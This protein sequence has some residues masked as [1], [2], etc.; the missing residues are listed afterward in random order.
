MEAVPIPDGVRG[1][2]HRGGALH[3]LR[4]A[5]ADR[6]VDVSVGGGDAR[7]VGDVEL[8]RDGG[9]AVVVGHRA[10]HRAGDR[11][12]GRLFVGRRRGR[13]GERVG[14]VP[15][16]RA[17]GRSHPEAGA[18]GRKLH[19]SNRPCPPLRRCPPTSRRTHRL[20]SSRHRPRFRRDRPR[21]RRRR[22]FRRDRR[23]SHRHRR[24][25]HDRRPPPRSRRRRPRQGRRR[26]RSTS[27]PAPAWPLVWPPAPA[28]EAPPLAPAVPFPPMP[29]LPPVD[30]ESEGEPELQARLPPRRQQR[31]REAEAFHGDQSH[32]GSLSRAATIR[33]PLGAAVKSCRAHVVV[34][35]R[36]KSS[37]DVTDEPAK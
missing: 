2:V 12:V 1:L 32:G 5:K 15:G 3:V 24:F 30:V 19:A 25:R 20:R 18:A 6:P 14:D 34:M 9:V 22:P 21:F 23:R 13:F 36:S 16:R 29:S 28:A 27:P 33:R 8:L 31:H 11:G 37:V 35:R 4:P 7:H 17:G 10:V 26:R